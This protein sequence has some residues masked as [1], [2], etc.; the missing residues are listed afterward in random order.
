MIT[1]HEMA[2][3]G[4]LKFL[5]LPI[6]FLML[7]I[8]NIEKCMTTFLK[9]KDCKNAICNIEKVLGVWKSPVKV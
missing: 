3:T 8:K 5:M 6:K 1:L 9:I 7:P 4:I 2:E